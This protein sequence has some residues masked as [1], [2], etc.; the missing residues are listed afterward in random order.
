MSI[1]VAPTVALVGRPNVGKST[2]FNQLTRT[3]DALVADEAGL[4]R[5]RQYGMAD[6]ADGYC[7]VVDT[8]GIMDDAQGLDATVAEQSQMAIEEADLVLFMVDGRSGLNSE[9]QAIAHQLRRHSGKTLLLMNKCEGLDLDVLASEFFSLGLGPPLGIASAHGQG[10]GALREAIAGKVA[11]PT[12]NKPKREHGRVAVALVGRPNAGK[13]TL[14]NRLIGENRVIASDVAGT[15]RDSVEVDFDYN[16]KPYVL[17]DTAGLRR[18]SKVHEKIEKFSIVKTLQAVDASNVVVVLVDATEG[19]SAQDAR[20]L[21]MIADTG[22]AI[23]VA[24][25]KW[26]GL[27]K[28]VRERIRS[29]IERKLPFLDYATF[30]TISALHGSKLKELMQA[31]AKAHKAAF[32]D[33]STSALSTALEKAVHAHPPPAV[34]GRRIKLSYAHQGGRN[35]PTIIIHGNQTEKLN[36]NYRRYLVN[37]FRQVFELHGTPVALQFKTSDNPFKD[38]K[39]KLSAGQQRKRDR[40]IKHR[41]TSKK[42]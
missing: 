36:Q 38:R 32:C 34:A 5:D 21:G 29:E 28:E 1:A 24:I 4:T 11:L 19:V 42:P 3:R 33:L 7:I 26:D 30:V 23:V 22:R 40:M 13:S 41:I 27:E 17:I 8:G 6:I 25:N 39:N 37:S 20:I 2:L 12:S 18:R 31:V 15:T 35:P 9:D 16:G 14:L 10:L